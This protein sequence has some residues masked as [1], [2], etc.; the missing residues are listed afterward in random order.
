MSGKG[1]SAPSA[2][3]GTGEESPGSDR[4]DRAGGSNSSR[5]NPLPKRIVDSVVDLSSS[6]L[7]SRSVGSLRQEDAALG[8]K[9]SSGPSTSSAG[10][11]TH[12]ALGHGEIRTNTSNHPRFPETDDESE[13]RFRQFLE[14]CSP[15]SG[16]AAFTTLKPVHDAEQ[17]GTEERTVDDQRRY[18]GEEVTALLADPHALQFTDSIDIGSLP[19]RLPRLHAALQG[20]EGLPSST[21]DHLLNFWPVADENIEGSRA[22]WLVQWKDVLT[23][24]TDDVWGD[25]GPDARQAKGEVEAELLRDDDERGLQSLRRLRQILAH[26]RGS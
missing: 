10:A 14:Q 12:Q 23:R 7:S 3:S 21:W 15:D 19:S 2:D 16:N 13:G 6:V 5:N 18:D 26:L 11:A 9:G 25:L 24:Y 8:D 1:P 22:A 4:S 20:G 17:S